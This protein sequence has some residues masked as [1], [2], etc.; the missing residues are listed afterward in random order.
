MGTKY[1]GGEQQSMGEIA[2]RAR[3]KL[4]RLP[5]V[6]IGWPFQCRC[7]ST[8]WVRYRGRFYSP[9]GIHWPA[10]FR[11]SGQFLTLRQAYELTAQLA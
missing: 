4:G 6:D 10:D 11:P 7:G 3:C 1:L 2:D 9:C 5:H 8:V